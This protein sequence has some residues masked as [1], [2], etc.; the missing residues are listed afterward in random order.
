MEE[1]DFPLSLEL[2]RNR[3]Q[4]DTVTDSHS[5]LSLQTIHLYISPL[6]ALPPF[7]LLSD[8]T[9]LLPSC[10]LDQLESCHLDFKQKNI[11]VQMVFIPLRLHGVHA[12]DPEFIVTVTQFTLRSQESQGLFFLPPRSWCRLSRAPQLTYG[13]NE[14]YLLRI[15]NFYVYIEVIKSLQARFPPLPPQSTVHKKR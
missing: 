14:G 5:S 10:C 6:I 13:D 11:S 4:I 15:I 2:S 12:V 8:R 9:S 1:E 3:K 7:L